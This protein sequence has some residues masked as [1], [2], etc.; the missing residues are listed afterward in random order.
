MGRTPASWISVLFVTAMFS[1]FTTPLAYSVFN[2]PTWLT[3]GVFILSGHV[4]N[5]ILLTAAGHIDLEQF[6]QATA[7]NRCC[8]VDGA[9]WR[10]AASGMAA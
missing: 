9:A 5:R 10:F 6:P 7:T 3:V 8:Q 2:T 1:S 4:T